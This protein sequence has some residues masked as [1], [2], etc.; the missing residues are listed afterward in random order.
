MLRVAVIPGDGIGNEVIPE[1][2]KV[3]EAADRIYEFGLD[4][5]TFDFG[6]GHYLRTGQVVPENFDDFI[7]ALPE[8]FD[9]ALFG[10]GGIDPRL[11]K[12]VH[13]QAVLYGLRT[14][15]DLFANVRPAKLLDAR[16]T[17]LK[18]KTEADIDFVVIRENTEGYES[19]TAGNF[20][21]GT[22]DEVEIRPEYNTFRG[23]S[24]V[25]RFAF[26]YAKQYGRKRVAMGQKGLDNGLWNRVFFDI[27]REY[28]G[29][30]ARQVHVDT[31]AYMIVTSPEELQVV[32]GENRIGDILSD[33]GGAVQGSR[34]LAASGN[35]NP[36]KGFC[37]FEPVHGTA[38]DIFGQNR[39]NPIAAITA[40]RMM[41][42]HFGHTD[43]AKGI[44]GAIAHAIREGSVT[45]DIGGTLSTQQVG[46]AV[47]AA[48][49]R[50]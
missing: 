7:Y 20:K 33:L 23:V 37:Y 10:A 28:P 36:D 39:S 25:V 48:L 3:L 9:A 49:T 30:E 5:Q 19:G 8:R 2:V 44:E 6:A 29:I 45:S 35:F 31:V 17:P 32:V 21:R 4:Y 18:G 22:P 1:A 11:P 38:P 12:G 16:L 15:L 40:A 13:G 47:I 24:R 42:D 27:A 50:S 46:A 43:A 14:G 41:L 34:G 26:D